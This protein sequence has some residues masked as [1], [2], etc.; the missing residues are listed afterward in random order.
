MKAG[1]GR[2]DPIGASKLSADRI[3]IPAF[4]VKPEGLMES[5]LIHNVP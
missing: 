1:K 2:P 4:P 3:R 5:L